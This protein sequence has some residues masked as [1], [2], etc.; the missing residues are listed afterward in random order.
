MSATEH[1]YRSSCHCQAVIV[2]FTAYERLEDREFILCN[3]SI[4]NKNGYI[5]YY[6]SKNN[7]NFVKGEFDLR[8]RN[9]RFQFSSSVTDMYAGI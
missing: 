3:C 5:N 8:V 4:C 6:V 9:L 2:D 1:Q 7:L